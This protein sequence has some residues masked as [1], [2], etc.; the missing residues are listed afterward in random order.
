[1]AVAALADPW[2]VTSIPAD[3]VP[4][5]SIFPRAMS[6]QHSALY[7]EPDTSGA[8]SFARRLLRELGF[9]DWVVVGYLTL[10]TVVAALAPSHPDQVHAL[11]EFGGLL[12]FVVLTV[13]L[14]RGGVLKHGFFAPL[15]YRLAIYGGV[16]LSYF[17]LGRL[18]P[19]VNQRTLD[20]Q[21][22]HLDLALFGVEPAIYMDR[23]VTPLTT[24]WFSFF[25][26]G[27]FFLLAVY[28][29]PILLLARHR[30]VLGE[31]ALGLILLF[32]IGHTVYM[33]V[34]GYGPY[35]ALAHEFA[36][37]LPAGT[38]H[39]TVMH[40]VASGGAMMDIFPSLHT[41]APTF[42]AMYS[43]RHKDKLPFRWAWLP[44]SFCA[45]NIIGATMFLRWHYVIDV[46]AGLV[47]S[48]SALGLSVT[49]TQLDHRRRARQRLGPS[50][51]E[52]QRS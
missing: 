17:F 13:V 2:H 27:Y 5:P 6:T 19:I 14:V 16:Q 48:A 45:I 39:D 21:L 8:R 40:T 38:W 44:V 12:A 49:L 37:P 33:L 9:Q 47:L 11:R 1:M 4:A 20:L 10:V 34:P 24:E 3:A 23:W 43:F 7:L 41:A 26:F 32:C 18:L 31:F 46:V 52:F 30:R 36:H 50:W 22:W 35:R 29:V 28:V 15:L 25:Y 42:L 51:P